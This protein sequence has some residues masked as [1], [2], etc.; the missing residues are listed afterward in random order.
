MRFVKFPNLPEKEIRFAAVSAEEPDFSA[1]GER[2]H[3]KRGF[4]GEKNA[5]PLPGTNRT[6]IRRRVPAPKKSN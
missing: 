5:G 6:R 4:G 1:R 3:G 2:G